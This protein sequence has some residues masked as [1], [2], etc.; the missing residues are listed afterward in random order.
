MKGW[1]SKRVIGKVHESFGSWNDRTRQIKGIWQAY[2]NGWIEGRLGML[3]QLD[4]EQV[5][6]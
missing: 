2:Y 3:H 4:D 6:E 5:R 1:D